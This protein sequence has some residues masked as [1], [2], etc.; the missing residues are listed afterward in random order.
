MKTIVNPSS[1]AKT[2][3]ANDR[4]V[5]HTEYA[6]TLVMT[7]PRPVIIENIQNIIISS[8]ENTLLSS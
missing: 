5:I 8:C 2:F 1:K 3:T 7:K 4:T 6:P